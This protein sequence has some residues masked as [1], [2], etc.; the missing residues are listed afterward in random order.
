M[1]ADEDLPE[2]ARFSVSAQRVA[3]NVG[4]DAAAKRSLEA[5]CLVLRLRLP[6]VFMVA[7]QA[8]FRWLVFFLEEACGLTR[9]VPKK[10]WV[11]LFSLK[12]FGSV[13]P[14]P[15]ARFFVDLVGMLIKC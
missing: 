4:D 8:F 6:G 5:A 12:S 15:K 10:D 14:K 13:P 11:L 1:L 2:K 3:A 9:G 7:F